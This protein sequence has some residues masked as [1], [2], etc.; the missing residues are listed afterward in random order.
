MAA[1][2]RRGGVYEYN[3]NYDQAVADCNMAIETDPKYMWGY[4]GRG[5]AYLDKGGYEQAV[6]DETSAIGLDPE[7]G[8]PYLER[9]IAYYYQGKY[10]ESWNDVHKAEELNAIASPDFLSKLQAASGRDD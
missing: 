8:W 7:I 3:G 6:A 4:Y 9:A 1:Y 10:D 2:F 5:Y